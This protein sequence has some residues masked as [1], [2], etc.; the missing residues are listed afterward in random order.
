MWGDWHKVPI[1]RIAQFILGQNEKLELRQYFFS[2]GQGGTTFSWGDLQV[3]PIF[4]LS[5]SAALCPSPRKRAKTSS[6]TPSSTQTQGCVEASL[7]GGL[8]KS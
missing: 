4:G 3:R 7:Q 6:A 5:A 2:R 1:F 8:F